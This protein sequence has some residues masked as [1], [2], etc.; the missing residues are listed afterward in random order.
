MNSIKFTER[1][2]EAIID[3]PIIPQ[4]G[5]DDDYIN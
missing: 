5:K 1:D 4:W 2:D 3:E